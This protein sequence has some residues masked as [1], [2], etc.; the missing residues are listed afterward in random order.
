ML[1]TLWDPGGE[2]LEV[3][4]VLGEQRYRKKEA[5]SDEVEKGREELRG[6]EKE[7]NQGDN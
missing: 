1:L 5:T 6:K 7:G 3:P 2:D 4:E